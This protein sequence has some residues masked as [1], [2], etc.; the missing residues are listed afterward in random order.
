MCLS[1]RLPIYLQKFSPFLYLRMTQF[2]DS[3]KDCEIEVGDDGEKGELSQLLNKSLCS[4]LQ[5]WSLLGF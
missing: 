2:R 5:L 4:D 3:K 1:D